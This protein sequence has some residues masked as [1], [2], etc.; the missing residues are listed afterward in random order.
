MIF[1]L[2]FHLF[3]ISLPFILSSIRDYNP[4]AMGDPSERTRLSL[5]V[6]L[7]GAKAG[8]VKWHTAEKTVIRFTSAAEVPFECSIK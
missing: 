4:Y 2:L 7:G 3:Y 8:A 5:V 6:L 1:H